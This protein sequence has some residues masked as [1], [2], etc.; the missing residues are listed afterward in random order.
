[1][2]KLIDA[3][4]KKVITLNGVDYLVYEPVTAGAKNLSV[5]LFSKIYRVGIGKPRTTQSSVDK[6]NRFVEQHYV[7]DRLL[8]AREDTQATYFISK[9]DYLSVSYSHHCPRDMA[10]KV[11]KVHV[12]HTSKISNDDIENA[13]IAAGNIR[14]RLNREYN[15]ILLAARMKFR[16]LV[17]KQLQ[18]RDKEAG[19]N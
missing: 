15:A 3:I 19:I 13:L 14:L 7:G 1:M 8:I 4:D 6:I 10:V 16:N 9:R 2:L 17:D 18:Q 11:K 5:N 12:G